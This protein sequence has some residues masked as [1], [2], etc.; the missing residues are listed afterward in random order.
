MNI[1]LK[2][3]HRIPVRGTTALYTLLICLCY[4]IT[5]F[6]LIPQTIITADEFVFMRHLLDYTHLM[7]YQDFLP[8]K[9][10]LGHYVLAIPL[11]FSQSLL[12]PIFYIK[13]EIACINTLGIALAIYWASKF[14]DKKAVL[15]T[16]LAILTNQFSI[17]Y[18]SDL[19]VDM[20]AAWFCLFAALSILQQRLPLAGILIGIAFLISQKALWYV[21]AI[22]GAMCIC[23]WTL[24]SYRLRGLLTLNSCT[25]GVVIAYLAFWSLLTSPSIVLS[26]FFYDAYIQA[27]INYYM[28]IYAPLWLM[29]LSH[30]P[31][32]FLLWPFTFIVLFDKSVPAIN[33]QRLF[34]ITFSAIALILFISYKQAFP[35]N[36]V[37]TLPAF[38]LCYSAFFTWLAEHKRLNKTY[39]TIFYVSFTLLG[40][41]W[42]FYLTWQAK[43]QFNGYYQQTMMQLTADLTQDGSDYIAGVPLLYGK[44]QPI[45]GI[46]NL[47]NPQIVY[48]DTQNKQLAP[49]LLPSIYL[50]ATT[51]AAVVDDLERSNVKVFI[52][53]YRTKA[54][55][56]SILKYI[57]DHYQHYYGSVYLYAPKID[58]E[59]LSFHLKF[60]ARYRIEA[61]VN[62]VI[63]IDHQRRLTGQVISLRK[64]DHL[65][66]AK[67][68]YRLVLIPSEAPTLDSRYE[69]DEWL[70]TL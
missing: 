53:N 2:Q 22:N 25:A 56:A 29:M 30:G 41:I 43:N 51:A 12:A 45:A 62:T 31:I 24:S 28:Q 34:T 54:L 38:F 65:S 58:A 47:I 14:F 1:S 35:Y 33:E 66:N 68:N 16:T 26:N 63:K 15:L 37:F 48:L 17:F 18:M 36:F 4:L 8:Y 67:M 50:S 32:L 10:T 64:G 13:M 49:L 70:K 44:D 23:W 27:G 3:P 7:P 39:L 40:I 42:P 57:S 20:L 19:R 9:S 52:T 61:K 11:F 55:S 60:T 6:I 59:Q 46:K 69:K 21:L 5:Q